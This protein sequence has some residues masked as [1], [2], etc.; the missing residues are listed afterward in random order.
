[1][2]M[3][4]ELLDNRFPGCRNQTHTEK[5]QHFAE[6]PSLVLPGQSQ[7]AGEASKQCQYLACSSEG[8]WV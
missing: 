7:G 4:Y 8:Y 3:R 2:Q 1:M 5:V 6:L